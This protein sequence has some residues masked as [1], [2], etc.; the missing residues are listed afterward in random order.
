[1]TEKPTATV[2]QQSVSCRKTAVGPNRSFAVAKIG[3]RTQ[4]FWETVQVRLVS[5]LMPAKVKNIP[6]PASI[7]L[8]AQS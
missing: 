3:R 4:V 2:L 8:R 6:N 1:M 7:H 5:N